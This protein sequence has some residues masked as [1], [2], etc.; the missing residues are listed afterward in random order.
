MTRL[1]LLEVFM[2]LFELMDLICTIQDFSILHLFSTL[3]PL[4][5]HAIVSETGLSPPINPTHPNHT[6]IARYAHLA[7]RSTLFPLF[8]TA[9]KKHFY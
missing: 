4:L 2:P 9:Q 1:Q 8:Q 7:Q 5:S 3:I 6:S